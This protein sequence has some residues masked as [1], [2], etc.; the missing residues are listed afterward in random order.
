MLDGM[1][2]PVAALGSPELA[3][4]LPE[5]PDDAAAEMTQ[6]ISGNRSLD[7]K[8]V[9]R[10]FW[11]NGADDLQGYLRAVE[12]FTLTGRADGIRCPFLATKSEGDPL[13]ASAPEM[14]EPLS[15]PT[16]L[17]SFTA[18]ERAGGHCEMQARWLLNTKVLDWLD[19]T[20][21]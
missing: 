15:C 5:L 13:A 9:K 14:V 7:W 6:V 2:G 20:L 8:I 4:N 3:D 10:G 18:A 17:L 16:T 19:D 11:V 12:P 21:A 1:R